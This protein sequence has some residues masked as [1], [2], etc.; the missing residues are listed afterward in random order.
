MDGFLQKP[1]F[2]DLSFVGFHAATEAF[3]SQN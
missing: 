1:I 3:V 2:V